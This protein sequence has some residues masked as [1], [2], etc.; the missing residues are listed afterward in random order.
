MYILFFKFVERKIF[1]YIIYKC[2]I[3]ITTIIG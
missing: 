2:T 3:I 1:S